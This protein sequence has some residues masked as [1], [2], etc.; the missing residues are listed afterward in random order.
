MVRHGKTRRQRLGSKCSPLAISRRAG[1]SCLTPKILKKISSTVR[2]RGGASKLAN[3]LGCNSNDGRCL[4]E[5][6]QLSSDEKKTLLDTFFR[7]KAPE[8]WKKDPDMWLTS[9]DIEVVMKQYEKAY[10]EFRFLGVVPI[11]FSAPDPYAKNEKCM[12]EQ[13]C[14][15]DLQEEKSKGRKIVGAVFNLDPHYKSGSHWVGLAI[16]VNRNYVYYFDSYGVPPPSQV[17]RFMRSLT[18]QNPN[19]KLQSNGRRFQYSDTECGM[20]SMYFLTQMIAGVSFKKFCKTPVPD[21]EMYL[22]RG[23]GEE[24]F[25]DAN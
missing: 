16:D 1:P 25:Y 7:P 10:P 22:L 4:V 11:D 5:K 19:L 20:Y 12:N 14:H 23:P 8:G 21:K 18:L 9:E 3:S 2:R 6:S 13:F 17:A 15:V 24:A